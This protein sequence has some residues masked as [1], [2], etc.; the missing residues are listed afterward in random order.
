MGRLKHCSISELHAPAPRRQILHM[1]R[2][3]LWWAPRHLA[4]HLAQVLQVLPDQHPH[5][6]TVMCI[7]APVRN[8]HAIIINRTQP[9]S[10]I[11]EQPARHAHVSVRTLQALSCSIGNRVHV[12]G[13]VLSS[14][15]SFP[16]QEAC[17]S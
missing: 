14:P 7:T 8:D 6:I 10:G 2:F 11:N 13:P 16:R 9:A 12:A 3:V 17:V 5:M 1:L 4:E 15:A